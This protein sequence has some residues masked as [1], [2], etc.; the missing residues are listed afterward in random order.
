MTEL[1][2]E[3]YNSIFP[4]NYIITYESKNLQMHILEKLY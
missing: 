4:E 2:E 3:T 1:G